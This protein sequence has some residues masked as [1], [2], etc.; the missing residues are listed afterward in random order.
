MPTPNATGTHGSSPCSRL[1]ANPCA[2]SRAGKKTVP[3]REED[4][5]REGKPPE[6]RLTW[7]RVAGEFRRYPCPPACG[8][9]TLP[10]PALPHGKTSFGHQAGGSCGAAHGGLGDPSLNGRPE[11]VL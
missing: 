11:E 7:L 6:W 2:R 1:G 4:H 8:G 5:A 3:V 10:R 9:L